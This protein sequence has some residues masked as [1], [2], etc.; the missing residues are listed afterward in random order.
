MKTGDQPATAWALIL[1][2]QEALTAA[3]RPQ[4]DR[5]ERYEVIC[6]ECGDDPN[7]IYREVSS[8][9][10]QIRGPYPF[11]AALL[12]YEQHAEMHVR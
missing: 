4:I 6:S 2:R 10:Q 5:T 3:G 8:K 12:A 11:S 9:L 1:R 7:L